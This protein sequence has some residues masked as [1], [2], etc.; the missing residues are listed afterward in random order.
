VIAETKKL[1]PNKRIKYIV[2]THPHFDHA[3]GWLRSV[4]KG[5]SF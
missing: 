1:F 2:N 5:R 4:P 3:S